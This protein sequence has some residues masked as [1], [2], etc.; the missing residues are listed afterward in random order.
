[1]GIALLG[2]LLVDGNGTLAPRDRVVLAALAVRRGQVVSVEQ[3]ADAVWS[4]QP[5]A[6]W[7]KQVHICVGRLRKTL[8]IAAIETGG[9]GYRLTL[10]GDGVDVDLFEEL[11]ERARMLAAT[12]EPERAASAFTRALALWRGRPFQDVDGWEPGDIEGARLEELRRNVEEELLEA[13]LDAGEHRDVAVAAGPLVTAE[14]LRER[15]WQILA[16]AQYRCGR[17][18]D[19][20]RTLAHARRR[21]LEDLGIDPGADL[22]ALEAAILRQDESLAGPPLPATTSPHC[23]YKGLSAFDVD[24]ADAFFGRDDE[25]AACLQ[26]LQT[27]TL[28]VV[29]GPSGCGKS[30]LA[31]AGLI[32][33]LARGGRT[34]VVLVPGV[35]PDLAMSQTLSAAEGSPVLVIDQFEELFAPGQDGVGLWAF[36]ERISAYARDQAPVVLCVR[37][38]HLTRLSVHP[39]LARLVEQGLHLVRPLTGD[40]LRVAIEMP[41]IQAG[42][43]LEHGLV[44]LLVRDVEGE[45]GALPL[46]SHALAETWARREDHVLTVDGYRAT[47]GINGAVAR[48]AD[49]LYDS[50]PTEQ[51]TL[52]RSLMLRLMAPSIEGDPVRCRLETRTLIGDRQREQVLALLVGARLVTTDADTVELAHESLARAWPRLRSWLDED[53]AGQRILRHLA[54]AAAGWDALGRPDSELYRGARLE[55]ALEWRQSDRRDL[56]EV[57]NQFLDAS[58]ASA[59]SEHDA[60]VAQARRDARQNRRLRRSLLALGV[61]AVAALL[62]GLVAFDQ[63]QD[64][65]HQATI[66]EEQRQ[67]AEDQADETR[68]GE[69]ASLS[70]LAI[71]EDPE[72]AILLGLAALARTDEPSAELLSALHRATQSNRVESTVTGEFEPDITQSADGSTLAVVRSDRT[73]Y[74]LIDTSTGQTLSDVT[75]ADEISEYGLAFDPTGSTLAV[76]ESPDDAS[77]PA[78]E[79]FDVAS[80]RRVTALPGPPAYYCCAQFDPTGRWLGALDV[81]GV[82]VVWDVATGEP[83]RA[84]GPAYDLELAPDGTTVVVGNG[85]KLTVFDIATGRPIREVDTPE[86]VEYW[87]FELDP[88]G[89][90]VALVST[91]EFARRV[92]V[93]DL[94]TGIVRRTL[95]LRD[96]LFVQFSSDGRQLAVSSEDSLVRVYDTDDFA[97]EHRLAG[98]SGPPSQVVFSPDGS[99][100]VAAG[101]GEIRTWDLSPAGPP[102]L[103]NFEVAGGPLDRLVVSGDESAALATMYTE[104]G[105]RSSL[106]RVDIPSGE[107]H[108][109]R[110]DIPY[111][112]S[113]RPLVSGDLSVAAVL[114]DDFVSQLVRLPSGGSNQLEPCESVRAFDA[115][116]RVAAVDTYLLCEERG[117]EATNASRIVDLESGDTLLELPD[118]AIY[119]AAFGRPGEDGR[120]ELAVVVD[121][122]SGEATFYDLPTGDAVGTVASDSGWPASIAMSVDGRRF[123]VLTD[124]GRLVVLDVA[125][126]ADGD[127]GTDPEL[128]DIV[129]H[130][131]GSK[132]VAFSPG[133]LIATGSSLDGVRVW[134]GDGE[135]VASVPT[136]QEDAPTF[137]FASGTD[138]LYYEDGDGLV[139]R[140]SFD[141]EGVTRLAR[142]VLTRGFTPQECT[143]YFPGEPCPDLAP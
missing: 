52:L 27:T 37:A 73:G 42:Y 123:A 54:I 44:D 110:G 2:P 106:Y 13:R 130:S 55:A 21:L 83:P 33:A 95:G 32:P 90:L 78:V 59:A 133:G 140:F 41:A 93:I 23:P 129:A 51:R 102:A 118:T 125:R 67:N 30:S 75:T 143:R 97:E 107:A 108:E 29:A 56:T 89:A 65:T 85:S 126:V 132:A 127:D 119:A 100:V 142:T 86:G 39:D 36:C 19:A 53:A 34:A 3:L 121:R 46:L 35:D 72:R 18:A 111:Y 24:D 101:A 138:T 6:S 112:F 122:D 43:R 135:L 124:T 96:P 87:D 84:I 117:Q 141:I 63:R 128:F 17:Q 109:L 58:H 80:G 82:A 134:S 99:R 68:A 115:G 120:P 60:L 69:L 64:A 49:R 10:V 5:P 61:F 98:T 45:P 48:S 22:I 28:L 94:E 92:D 77:T 26:R 47:G 15:R 104:S 16:L 71:D 11:I 103:G 137:A 136:R 116:G 7:Q 1:V 14:P 38:D 62:T 79:L 114:D 88:A 131:T 105:L 70:S 81:E 40:A 57:E 20:L 50:L 31:R 66:A 8:G 25:V 76:A 139:R 113:T 12:G 91:A 74:L 4:G 9:G